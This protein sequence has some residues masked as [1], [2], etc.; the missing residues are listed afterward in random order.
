[1]E[2][3]KYDVCGSDNQL[4]ASFVWKYDAI[5]FCAT[6]CYGDFVT[7]RKEIIYVSLGCL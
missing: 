5:A 2:S 6:G 4:I 7:D 3:L 1:M